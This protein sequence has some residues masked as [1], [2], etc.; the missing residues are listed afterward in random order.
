MKKIKYYI[1]GKIKRM[2]RKW[3]KKRVY[4]KELIILQTR[5][6]LSGCMMHHYENGKTVSGA[7]TKMSCITIRI[8][9]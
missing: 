7:S 2:L 4:V 3:L 6:A 1:E 8:S 5:S 9:F